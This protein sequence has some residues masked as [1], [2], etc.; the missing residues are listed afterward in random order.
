MKTLF[1]AATAFA[2]ATP[3][4]AQPAQ[5]AQP[6]QQ[7][8]QG[9]AQ[10][11]QQTNHGSMPHGMTMDCCRDANNNGKMDCCENMGA[12]MSTPSQGGRQAPAAQ[13]QAHQ[14]H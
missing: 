10:H 12:G 6:A 4:A 9:H 14:G 3:A 2:F 8:H 7:S 1:I 11:G 5:P 13:P